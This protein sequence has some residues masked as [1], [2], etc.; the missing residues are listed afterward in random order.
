MAIERLCHQSIPQEALSKMITPLNVV[1]CRVGAVILFVQA[2]EN[3]GVVIPQALVFSGSF[4]TTMLYMS[5]LLATPILGGA[6]LWIYGGRLAH[7]RQ[8]ASLDTDLAAQNVDLVAVGTFVLGLYVLLLGITSAAYA[9]LML[10]SES[11]HVRNN[12][13]LSRQYMATRVSYLIQIG[14]GVLLVFGRRY[15]ARLFPA[16][17]R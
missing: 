9:E 2:A 1:L 6:A 11:D 15:I 8:D 7:V 16:T 3:V 5:L 13:H 12:P 17:S 10:L 4:N 14:I